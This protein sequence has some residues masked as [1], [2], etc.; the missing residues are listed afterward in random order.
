MIYGFIVFI[1]LLVLFFVFA[2]FL[3]LHAFL[4]MV[5]GWCVD[6][7][8]FMRNDLKG[9][10]VFITGCDSG[11]GFRTVQ[12]LLKRGAKVYANC[13][14]EQG[15]K[16]LIQ[17]CIGFQEGDLRTMVFDVRDE[18]KIIA[19]RQEIEREEKSVYAVI[20]N[21][22][23]ATYGF[24]E[25]TSSEDFRRVMDVNFFAPVIVCREFLPLLRKFGSSARIINISSVGGRVTGSGNGVGPYTSSKFAIEAVSDCL[26]REL[27]DHG[28]SVS[29]IQP[30]FFKTGIISELLNRVNGA[31]NNLSPELQQVYKNL[32]KKVI[33][34]SELVDKIA[35]NPEVVA[36]AIVR[37]TRAKSPILRYLVGK[38]ANILYLPLSQAPTN[39]Q[40]L[41]FRNT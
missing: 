21:A 9:K 39:V 1:E 37:N 31:F 32:Q 12:K 4:T 15:A 8:W 27:F 33:Q 16:D 29:L 23:I 24:V 10:V 5:Y 38:Q 6:L 30:A 25:G 19:A 41:F 34:R 14:S 36:D 28:I 13:Y 17:A 26:R 22:G 40:D 20:N 35:E 2:P 3:Y 7:F 11:F 18:S